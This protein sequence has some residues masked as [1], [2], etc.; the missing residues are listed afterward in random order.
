MWEN[1]FGEYL[2]YLLKILEF[3]NCDLSL[4]NIFFKKLAKK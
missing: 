4:R 3:T 1:I 2:M